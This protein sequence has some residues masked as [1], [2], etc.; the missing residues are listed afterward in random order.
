MNTSSIEVH[1]IHGSFTAHYFV[2]WDTKTMR[3]DSE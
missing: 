3:K 2:T 1:D